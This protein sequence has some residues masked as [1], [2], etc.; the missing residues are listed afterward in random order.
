[1]EINHSAICHKLLQMSPG[2]HWAWIHFTD[3]HGQDIIYYSGFPR[4]KPQGC[5]SSA[6]VKLL[7]GIFDQKWDLS[8]F[9][10]RNRIYTS[11]QPSKMDEGM[12]RLV[13]K[14]CSA[15]S[16]IEGQIPEM[17]WVQIGEIDSLFYENTVALVR[18]QLDQDFVI[19]PTEA[20]TL[21]E[22]QIPRGGVLHDSPREI[23]A[24]LTD[25]QGRV[26]EYACHSGW[27]NK[28]LHAEVLVLQ[29][30]FKRTGQGLPKGAQLFTS[31]KPCRMCSEM[32]AEMAGEEF[33]V[34]YKRN[35]PGPMAQGSSIDKEMHQ[36]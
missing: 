28:T 5:P 6:V 27:L 20:L 14:R 17:K 25:S 23:A 21:L 8:F 13:A 1:M 32:L 33:V 4:E 36:L 24:I 19:D 35:D 29:R 34:R 12:V 2:T 31:L 9:I 16:P 15:S 30:Y 10:L 18:A 11:Y 3:K 22:G 26:L 7:Q